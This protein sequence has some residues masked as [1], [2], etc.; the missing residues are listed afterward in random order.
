MM[1]FWM[2]LFHFQAA[3][4]VVNNNAGGGG[5]SLNIH[6][7][8]KRIRKKGMFAIIQFHSFT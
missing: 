4:E 3:A 2:M 5:M 6:L 8:V 1:A 7:I